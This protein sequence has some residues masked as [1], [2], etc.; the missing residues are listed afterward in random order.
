MAGKLVNIRFKSTQVEVKGIKPPRVL[1]RWEL[2]PTAQDLSNLKFYIYRGEADTELKALNGTGIAHDDI[3]EFMDRTA[4]LVDQTKVY[5][6]QVKGIEFDMSGNPVQ[7]FV[8]ETVSWGGDLDIVGLY[9]VDEH[10]FLYE[11]VSGTPA[12]VFRRRRDG[13]RCTNCWDKVLKRVTDSQCITC[14]GTGYIGG[15]YPPFD[16]WMHF[17]PNPKTAGVAQTGMM[18]NSV[19]D[20]EFTNYPEIRVGDIIVELKPNNLWRVDN[21]RFTEKNKTIMTQKFG[22]TMINRSDIEYSLQV[23]DDR[24]T[25]LL[26]QLEKRRRISEF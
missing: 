21:S 2:Q 16:A 19:S 5:K 1:V 17:Y 18:Q 9:V 10:L 3:Y 4:M 12:M 14:Y 22:T 8:S 15:Y 7:E 13:T 25:N 11:H 20:I 26:D 24:R 23:P 6:Y